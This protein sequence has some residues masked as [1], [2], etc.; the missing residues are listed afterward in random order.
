MAQWMVRL[1]GDEFDLQTLSILYSEPAVR[2]AQNDGAYYLTSDTFA[3]LAES[4]EVY[5]AATDL[6]QLINPLTPLRAANYEPVLVDS[7]VR[8][9]ENGS[10]TTT[11]IA[12]GV[13]ALIGSARLR[14]EG[15]VLGPDGQPVPSP[16]PGVAQA[17]LKLA[18]QDAN[19]KR[20]LTYWQRCKPG[21]ADVCQYAN[22]VYEVIREDMA[23]GGHVGQGT[24]TIKQQKWATRGEIDDFQ[25][26]ANSPAISGEK[27]RHVDS[28]PTKP[29]ITPL[30][31]S[32]ALAFIR[33]LFNYWLD[34][35]VKQTP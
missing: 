6:L 12:S 8:L 35:K 29:G 15:V 31:D 11:R 28:R 25:A 14:G 27:A 7:V 21:D 33:R 20:A 17:R 32:E 2:V 34:W 3:S 26:W 22:K 10:R 18:L 23:S 13:V 24:E 5:A 19:I 1:A 9:N 30:S 4:S 16:E